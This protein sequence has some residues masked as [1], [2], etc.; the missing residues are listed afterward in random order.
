[1]VWQQRCRRQ[2]SLPR[3]LCFHRRHMVLLNFLYVAGGKSC[4]GPLASGKAPC[5]DKLVTATISP[6]GDCSTNDEGDDGCDRRWRPIPLKQRHPPR[7]LIQCQRRPQYRPCSRFW[8]QKPFSRQR[9]R[10]ACLW[11]RPVKMSTLPAPPHGLP[12]L[13]FPRVC[14]LVQGEYTFFGR[15]SCGYPPPLNTFHSVGCG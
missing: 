9:E 6:P 8:R 1:M 4:E 3:P 7:W 15:L 5:G 12:P 2:C 14:A 11:S 10:R 13:S